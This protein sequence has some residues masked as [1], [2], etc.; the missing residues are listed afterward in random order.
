VKGE[1]WGV[2][3]KGG[4]GCHSL[5]RRID[6]AKKRPQKLEV[7]QRLSSFHKNQADW[8]SEDRHGSVEPVEGVKRGRQ[9]VSPPIDNRR[10]YCI[11]GQGDLKGKK[12]EER[13]MGCGNPTHTGDLA[14]GPLISARRKSTGGE[15]ADEERRN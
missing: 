13:G 15:E 10:L 7:L 3:K 5:E 12:R 6:Q 14:W 11:W 1:G 2:L 8:K 9:K 4:T